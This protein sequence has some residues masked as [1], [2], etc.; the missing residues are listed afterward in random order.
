MAVSIYCHMKKINYFYKEKIDKKRKWFCRRYPVHADE[1]EFL[2]EAVTA[3][4][5]KCLPQDGKKQRECTAKM[6]RTL[7]KLKPEGICIYRWKEDA[8]PRELQLR[9]YRDC[10][11][12]HREAQQLIVFAP[13]EP[14]EQDVTMVSEMCVDYNYMTIVTERE[15]DW[16]ELVAAIYEE[17]GLLAR[18]TTDDNRL[19]FPE[20]K[21]VV[22]D[23]GK[24]IKKCSKNLPKDSV[25]VDL[26]ESEEKRHAIWVK[27]RNIPYFSMHN[28]LDTILKCTV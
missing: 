10:R 26:Y 21:A 16:E 24:V 19:C 18:C 3:Y 25:Y 22:A 15:G 17:Q 9:F 6:Q 11:N 14:N 5:I 7:D 2:G 23:L 27:C 28:A 13:M 8:F 4:G 20:K 1:I 12:R